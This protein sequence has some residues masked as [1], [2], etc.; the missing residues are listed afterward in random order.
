[1]EGRGILIFESNE[2]IVVKQL[3]SLF[4]LTTLHEH[5]NGFYNQVNVCII[6]TLCFSHLVI[7]V[8]HWLFVLLNKNQVLSLTN[9][10][11]TAWEILIMKGI[12][13]AFAS[14]VINMIRGF[15][16]L[17]LLLIRC[18][19]KSITWSEPQENL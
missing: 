10:L 4:K 15:L 13:L 7:E 12:D 17:F 6:F 1:M 3:T 14:I 5:L 2:F 19:T 18:K 8:K 9:L 11:C 16:H